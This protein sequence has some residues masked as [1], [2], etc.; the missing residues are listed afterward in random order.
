MPGVGFEPMIPK[1]ERTKT[2]YASDHAVTVI[3]SDLLFG[4]SS[5]KS[6][7]KQPDIM[8]IIVWLIQSI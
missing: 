3:D 7:R 8:D 5:Q 4:L 6:I 1:L 2:F